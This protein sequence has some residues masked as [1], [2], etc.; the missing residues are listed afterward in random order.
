MQRNAP[1]QEEMNFSLVLRDLRKKLGLT[2]A[3]MAL[4]LK[5]S[6]T[7]LSGWE[8]DKHQPM[9]A[10]ATRIVNMARRAGVLEAAEAPV[11]A[12]G[13]HLRAVPP[14]APDSP[15]GDAPASPEA[16]GAES[17]EPGEPQESAVIDTRT[18]WPRKAAERRDFYHR[19]REF[20]PEVAAWR[21]Q[22]VA[23]I[24]A[25]PA[26]F[27]RAAARSAEEIRDLLDEGIGV[28]REVAE[29]AS[30]LYGNPTL[31]NLPDP[32][33]ELIYIILSRKTPEV[34]YQSAYQALKS[35]YPTWDAVL[36]A[37]DEDI[38]G[39]VHHGGL[40]ATKTATIRAA[41]ERLRQ[42]FGSCTL[43]PARAWPDAKLEAFLCELPGISRKSAYCV[44][45]FAFSRAVLPVDTHVGRVLQRL[46][47]HHQLGLD[48]AGMDHKQL[49]RALA[50]LV[51]PNLRRNL[52]VNLLVHGRQVCTAATPACSDC[53]LRKFCQHYRRETRDAFER[54]G[55]PTVV[56]LF[57]GAGGLSEGFRRSGFRVI[58]AVDTNEVA[59]R[60]FG[61]NHPELP[62][63]AI[64]AADLVTLSA[65]DL[66]KAIGGRQID[67]LIGAPPCQGFSHVGHRSKRSKHG[68]SREVH[69]DAR[70]YL[71]EAFVRLASELKPHLV[72]MEN[73]PGM[74]SA[75]VQNRSFVDLAMA[76]LEAC[77]YRATYW[78]LDATAF[79]VPQERTR[80]FVVGSRSGLLPARPECEYKSLQEGSLDADALPQVT[81]SEA[82][83]DLPPLE[84]GDGVA[85]TKR[86]GGPVDDR[87]AR[88]YL[89][90]FR[91]LDSPRVIF[92]H[93]TRYNNELDLELYALLRQGE[94]SG[95]FL[96]RTGRRDLMRYRTDAF[97]DKYMRLDE[98]SPCRT[99]VA[100]LAK[101]GNGYVH[102]RQ[103]RSLSFREA[104]RVQSFSDSFAFCGSPSDQWIQLGNAVPPVLGEAI[105]RSFSACIRRI[106]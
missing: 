76:R 33:D 91:L 41:L 24:Q 30:V 106:R 21:K 66:R 45:L 18:G 26:R 47:V 82:I 39:H 4:K 74:E 31:G 79:G 35:A 20:P 23:A 9:R 51:P 3:E 101:D 85:V 27:P 103:T 15:A 58:G 56:D 104:A 13:K 40:G 54:V 78:K 72:V 44:M 68:M 95:N 29:I 87:R 89:Q 48:L 53:D 50:D 52:H 64:L 105:A 90:K 86:E 69:G 99:I 14:I 25:D 97:D 11:K 81:L 71:F 12:K 67:V 22:L 61:L 96:E 49:Q 16:A 38:L 55:A 28:L 62:Q 2:Q 1:V 8:T 6:C 75:R 100:H 34:E 88:R 80:I 73:V 70:N 43:E 59:L 10:H 60:T 65:E 46:G 63:E 77:G 83:F 92:N 42:E 32:V 57:C 98:N 5:I 84:A 36:A 102:P 94:D 19:P 37:S 7:T 93:T 17:G